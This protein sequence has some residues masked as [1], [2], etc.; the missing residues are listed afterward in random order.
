MSTIRVITSSEV[1]SYEDSEDMHFLFHTEDGSLIITRE[2]WVD[3]MFAGWYPTP[4]AA[5][6]PGSWVRVK[7]GES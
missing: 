4:V 7:R 6:A 2:V 1:Y 5:Y 3:G